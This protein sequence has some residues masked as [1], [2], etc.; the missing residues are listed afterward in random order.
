VHGEKNVSCE[1]CGKLYTCVENLRLH[2]RYHLPPL[3]ECSYPD[4]G[5]KFHQKVLWEHHERKHKAEKP[6][7]CEQC[8][9]S[10]YSL[11]DVKRHQQRVHEKVTRKCDYCEISFSRKDKYRQH[12]IKK[13]KELTDEER[14]LVLEHI[15]VMK[16]VE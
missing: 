7:S 11:R 5:K 15:R 9:A 4:C 2:M 13:H 6:V 10:F 8:G 3:F 16:W 1:T 12:I 14:E